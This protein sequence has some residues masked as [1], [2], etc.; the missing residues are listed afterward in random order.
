[1]LLK[2]AIIK[3]REVVSGNREVMLFLPHCFFFFFFFSFLSCLKTVCMVIGSGDLD[4]N[5]KKNQET[6]LVIFYVT[7]CTVSLN[8]L[9]LP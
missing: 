4:F 7:C 5:R 2:T 1:M 3:R 6:K 9:S 8:F